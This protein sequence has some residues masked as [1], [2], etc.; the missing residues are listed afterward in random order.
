MRSLALAVALGMTLTTGGMAAQANADGPPVTCAAATLTGQPKPAAGGALTPVLLVHGFIG[1]PEMWHKPIEL[2]TLPGGVNPPYRSLVETLGALPGAAVYTLDYRRVNTRW[3]SNLGGGGEGFIAAAD[4]LTGHPAFGGHKLIVVAHSMGGLITRWA[5]TAAP[6]GAKRAQRLGLAITLG[7][8]FE[9]SWLAAVVANI[10]GVG[11]PGTFEY[12]SLRALIHLAIS[13]CDGNTNGACGQLRTYLDAF[14]TALAF[15]P[16]SAELRALPPWPASVRVDTLSTQSLLQDV[17]GGGFFF[18]TASATLDLGD[19]VVAVRSATS[20]S[21]PERTFSCRYTA[22]LGRAATDR[23]LIWAGQKA[24]ID[25]PAVD[26]RVSV[27]VGAMDAT[28]GHSAQQRLI[29][30]TNEVLGAVAEQLERNEPGYAYLTAKEL[31]V[32]HGTQVTD[33]M[34]GHFT[35]MRHTDD[36]RFVVAIENASKANAQVSALDLHS[37]QRHNVSCN[38]CRSAV[39]AGGSAVAWLDRQNRIMKADLGTADLPQQQPYRLPAPAYTSGI[40][41][42]RLEAAQGQRL[43]VSEDLVQGASIK[44]GSVTVLT[45]DGK[46]QRIR[47]DNVGSIIAT[48]TKIAFQLRYRPA[49]CPSADGVGLVASDNLA[50]TST[51]LGTLGDNDLLRTTVSDLWWGRDGSLYATMSSGPCLFADG[52]VA[53]PGLY[54]LDG[55]RW[56]LVDAGPLRALRQ[57]TARTKAVVLENGV[58]YTETDGKGTEIAQGVT[59]ID[60]PPG[61]PDAATTIP[62]LAP[63]PSRCPTPAEFKAVMARYFDTAVKASGPEIC[64]DDWAYGS[65]AVPIPPYGYSDGA[66]T[67][68][69]RIDG[70]WLVYQARGTGAYFIGLDSIC[71]TVPS[72]IKEQICVSP[73]G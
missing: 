70:R 66:H 68:L 18:R 6:G 57:L 4:C 64:Q 8:P 25:T 42:P 11:P 35:A 15:I 3:F 37:G 73:N 5:V 44:G 39:P 2:S 43:L 54:R 55:H 50:L 58:L 41:P 36:G 12:E 49:N 32:V 69:H 48:G 27:V 62:I 28:C 19:G 60:M 47:T 1:S 7:T 20:G 29:N 16:G 52:S 23:L 40:D 46:A 30:V 9:G 24:E 45:M 71:V 10:L 63:G 14:G 31:A 22:D 34:A 13:V 17:G 59:A 51:D 53:Q 61:P 21:S 26:W 65:T 38:G 33:R 72:R 56:R 67:L